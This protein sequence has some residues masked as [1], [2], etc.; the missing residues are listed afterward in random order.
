MTDTDLYTYFC[1]SERLLLDGSA[2]DYQYLK[3][4]ADQVNGVDDKQ[5][6]AVLQVLACHGCSVPDV[7][8]DSISLYIARP[9]H[10]RVHLG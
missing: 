10:R 6:W 1:L 5:E 7:I 4:S 8:I 2:R 9:R 3:H